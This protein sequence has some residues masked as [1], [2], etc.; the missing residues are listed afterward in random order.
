MHLCYSLSRERKCNQP[1]SFCCVFSLIPPK[2]EKTSLNFFPGAAASVAASEVQKHLDRHV[3]H[4][5]M[6]EHVHKAILNLHEDMKYV[7]DFYKSA[8]APDID[9]TIMLSLSPQFAEL[10]LKGRKYSRIYVSNATTQIAV[11]TPRTGI[12]T[13]TA[14]GGWQALDLQDGTLVWLASGS[15]PVNILHR[16]SNQPLGGNTI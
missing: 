3:H 15:T 12:Y 9:E 10:K 11:Q 13:F 16:V 6:L 1:L 8:A 14:S 2:G 4:E 5:T 7:S